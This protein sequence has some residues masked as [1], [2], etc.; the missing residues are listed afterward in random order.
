VN[1]L[2]LLYFAAWVSV[3]GIPAD[4]HAAGLQALE[5]QDYRQAQEIFSKLSAADPKDYS[6]LFNLALAETGLK[7]D[8]Q[9]AEHYRQVLSLKPGLYPAELNL[10]MVYLRDHKPAEAVPLLRDAAAKKPDQARPERYLGDSLLA[11]GDPAGAA[12][13]YRQA[14]N[15]DPKMGPAELG[16]GQALLRQ[17]KL[18][19]AAPH[20]RQAAAL[21]ANLKSF[22]LELGAAYSKANRPQDA[23]PLLQQF[24]EDA[25]AREEL[26]RIYLA[27]NRPAEAVPQFQAAVQV[28][29]TPANKLALATA[30]LKNNQPDLADPILEQALAADPNDYDLHM[31]VGRIRRDKHDYLHAAD[32]FSTAAKLKPDSVEAWNEAAASFVLAGL[33]PQGLAALDKIRTLNAETAGDLYFRAVALDHMHEVKP[34]LA[35]YQQFLRTSGGKYPDQEFIARQRSRILEKEANR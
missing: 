17:G 6:A 18:D 8:D 28:S 25:G 31:A 27:Q 24:P 12:E 2:T 33:Y 14:L 13:A 34:A 4:P 26:G 3:A 21:D 1:V 15:L 9:A 19:E 29:P 7:Q 35:S 32:Q 10:G 11:T 5:H 30:Y 20:Y 23:I 16:L 22:L